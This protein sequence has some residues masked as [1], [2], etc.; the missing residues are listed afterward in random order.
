MKPIII[1]TSTQS[2][3][4][5]PESVDCVFHRKGLLSI[6]TRAGCNVKLTTETDDEVFVKAYEELTQALEK[7][8]RE[9]KI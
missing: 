1:R 2:L 4:I 6:A 5:R 9:T 8:D 7:N 3:S